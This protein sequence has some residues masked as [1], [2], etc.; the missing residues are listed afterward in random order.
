MTPT[1]RGSRKLARLLENAA[2]VAAETA[3]VEVRRLV[4]ELW[5]QIFTVV[6]RCIC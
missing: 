2:A 6:A 3:E 4:G 1:G 5:M